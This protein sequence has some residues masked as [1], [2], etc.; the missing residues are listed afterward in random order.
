MKYNL[1]TNNSNTSNNSNFLSKDKTIKSS[2]GYLHYYDFRFRKEDPSVITKWLRKNL[3]ERGN[4]Y[5]FTLNF[6]A[7]TMQIDIWETKLNFIYEIWIK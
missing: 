6:K 3:G 5:D 1:S 7:G 4:G 2:R